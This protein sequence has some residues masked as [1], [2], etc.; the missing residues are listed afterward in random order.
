MKKENVL[1]YVGAIVI[2]LIPILTHMVSDVFY[3]IAA[4]ISLLLVL[5][6]FL[7]LV[8]LHNRLVSNPIPQLE[9]R[10]GDEHE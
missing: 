5:W 7:D 4:M 1:K 8:Q 2:P 10:G 9:K 6:S 3:Y